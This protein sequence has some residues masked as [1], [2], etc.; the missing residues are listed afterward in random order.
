[1]SVSTATNRLIIPPSHAPFYQQLRNSSVGFRELG[2]KLVQN[3][4]YCYVFRKVKQAEETARLL[5]NLPL[6]QYQ[7]IG[8]YYLGW[9]KY[10]RGAD[11]KSI[12]ERVAEH[13][14]SQY[15]AR[16]MHTLA[17]LA[18]KEGNTASELRWIVESMKVSPSLEG[19]R[20]MAIVKA[21]EG[22]HTSSLKDLEACMPL[23]RYADALSYYDYL[24]SYAVELGESGRTDEA[25]N[26]TRIVLAS[27]LASFYPEWQ[28]TADDLKPVS[29]S[30]VVTNSFAAINQSQYIPSNVVPMPV[31]RHS[32]SENIRYNWPAKV[33]NLQQWKKK[34][35][36]DNDKNKAPKTRREMMLRLMEIMSDEEL[37]DYNLERIL[38]DAERIAS[39]SK[40]KDKD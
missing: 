30:F 34:M 27:P 33:F 1:M 7:L 38:K 16:A 9:C 24:N 26:I 11:V 40:E 28:A 3:A 8:Q 2:A 36:K 15:R 13:A 12:F 20:G 19:L 17:A 35:V 6:R 23:A 4:E 37:S 18:A 39:E 32:K 22:F 29:R 25:H 14:P 31:V 5:I 10:A 21:R